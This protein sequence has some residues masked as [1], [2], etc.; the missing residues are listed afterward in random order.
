MRPRFHGKRGFNDPRYENYKKAL[1]MGIYAQFF[2]HVKKA[3]ETGSKERSRFLNFN[4][5]TLDVKAYRSRNTGDVDNYVKAAQDALQD[6]GLILDDCQI[7]R[8]TGEKFIDK[9]RP[10]LEVILVQTQSWEQHQLAIGD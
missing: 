6:S 9:F 5:Y 2:I 4:R 3:P 8:I 1:S 7:D 10:R